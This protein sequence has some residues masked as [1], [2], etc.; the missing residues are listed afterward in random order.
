MYN[1]SIGVSSQILMVQAGKHLDLWLSGSQQSGHQQYN[2]LL[3]DCS[4]SIAELFHPPPFR[5]STAEL[6]HPSE[7]KVIKGLIN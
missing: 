1:N 3:H 4:Y 7:F 5:W 2:F 6:F